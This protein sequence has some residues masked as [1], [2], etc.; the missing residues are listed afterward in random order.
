MSI[1]LRKF[2]IYRESPEEWSKAN[3]AFAVCGGLPPCWIVIHESGWMIG[4]VDSFD[5]AVKRLDEFLRSDTYRFARRS[6]PGA[7][8]QGCWHN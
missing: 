5:A 1:G 7:C 3:P 8:R 4:V 2:R 6:G